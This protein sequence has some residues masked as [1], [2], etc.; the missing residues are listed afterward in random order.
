[1]SLWF[2]RQTRVLWKSDDLQSFSL[3]L[4]H[5][6]PSSF[7]KPFVLLQDPGVRGSDSWKKMR[8]A[9]GNCDIALYSSKGTANSTGQWCLYMQVNSGT[10]PEACACVLGK[11]LHRGRSA[12]SLP[13]GS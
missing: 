1:M 10:L 6:G 11:C 7:A 9:V 3:S 2:T 5:S 8:G 13:L 4:S 12:K